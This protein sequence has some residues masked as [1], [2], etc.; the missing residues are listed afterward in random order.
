MTP[1]LWRKHQLPT[2][3]GS[4][5]MAM[6][7]RHVVNLF[8]SLIDTSPRV[9]CEIGSHMGHSTVAF[10]EAMY[11]LPEME[12]HVF[13]LH[14]TPELRRILSTFPD[15]IALHTTPIWGSSIRPDFAFI[16]G[17]HGVPALADLAYCLARGVP[18]IAMHDTQSFSCGLTA[19][20]SEQAAR[21]LREMPDRM[22]SEDKSLR[23]GEWTHRGF[24]V[25][26]IL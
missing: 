8:E 19:E 21:L 10:I 22:W 17:D 1:H 14:P 26:R 13:E 18:T 25:S 23:E 2:F 15:R 24:G 16:D 9:A 20:G 12:L 4:P 11:L 6:D 3:T 7:Y 5:P